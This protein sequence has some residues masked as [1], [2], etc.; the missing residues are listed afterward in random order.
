MVI[1][2]ELVM[3]LPDGLS[4]EILANFNYQGNFHVAEGTSWLVQVRPSYK[5]LISKICNVG[6]KNDHQFFPNVPSSV[7]R[8]R[9]QPARVWRQR[10]PGKYRTP[11]TGCHWLIRT[12][13]MLKYKWP[14][15]RKWN[16]KDSLDKTRPS[17]S[18][19]QTNNPD[20]MQSA[21]PIVNKGQVLNTDWVVRKVATV[22]SV[23]R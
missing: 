12:D 16:K 7:T 21:E 2:P 15:A 13:Y 19:P 6:A 22:L 14:N 11:R 18:S 8:S 23:S 17:P 10:R 4:A 20:S 5:Q 9:R 1:V 3:K